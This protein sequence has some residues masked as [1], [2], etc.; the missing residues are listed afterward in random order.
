MRN[1][2]GSLRLGILLALVFMAIAFIGG[3]ILKQKL[4]APFVSNAH[5]VQLGDSVEGVRQKML[6]FQPSTNNLDLGTFATPVVI[7]RRFDLIW[8]F[9]LD[10]SNR[11]ANVEKRKT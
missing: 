5:R 8:I 11:V 6:P 1:T 4:Y 2:R 10:S 9:H 7:Y 3:S